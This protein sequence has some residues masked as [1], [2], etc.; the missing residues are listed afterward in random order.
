MK[1]KLRP[2]V[3]VGWGWG[4]DQGREW[5]VV[6]KLRLVGPKPLRGRT[7]GGGGGG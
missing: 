6:G 5:K 1:Q 2:G 3:C 7:V 4:A